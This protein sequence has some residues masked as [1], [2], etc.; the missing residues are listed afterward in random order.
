MS[1]MRKPEVAHSRMP[2]NELGLALR[3]YEVSQCH[4]FLTVPHTFRL[5]PH[6]AHL[7]CSLILEPLDV[8]L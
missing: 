2:R 4:A 1:F 8:V 3:D 7:S 6:P 5:P